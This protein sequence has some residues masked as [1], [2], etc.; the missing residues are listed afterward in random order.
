MF[1]FDTDGS[2]V[3]EVAQAHA[4]CFVYVSGTV[5]LMLLVV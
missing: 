3:S 5:E 4:D 2:V 1:S